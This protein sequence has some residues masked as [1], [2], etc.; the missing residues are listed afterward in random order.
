MCGICYTYLYIK[1]ICSWNTGNFCVVDCCEVSSPQTTTRAFLKP[2]RKSL[3]PGNGHVRNTFKSCS[4]EPYTP[5]SF[6]RRLTKA[7]HPGYSTSVSNKQNYSS[8]KA[9]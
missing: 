9:G 4:P 6:M 5:L 7:P 8:Q 2:T 1:I 3:L